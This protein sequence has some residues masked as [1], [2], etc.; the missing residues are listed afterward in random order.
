[1]EMDDQKPLLEQ[2]TDVVVDA[3]HA[4][5]EAAKTAVKKVKRRPEK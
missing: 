2:M 4:T 1:M 3:A 5:K